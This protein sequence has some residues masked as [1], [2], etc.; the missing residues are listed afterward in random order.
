M[1]VLFGFSKRDDV[2]QEQ[3]FCMSAVIVAALSF[4]ALCV[5]RNPKIKTCE[6]T[7]SQVQKEEELQSILVKDGE[8]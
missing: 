6:E 5:V 4:V 3:A 1:S 7:K 8:K 2:N